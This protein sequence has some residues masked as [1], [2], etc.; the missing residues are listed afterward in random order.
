MFREGRNTVTIQ[1]KHQVF[2]DPIINLTNFNTNNDMI[3]TKGISNSAFIRVTIH[4]NLPH[5]EMNSNIPHTWPHIRI[6]DSF[7]FQPIVPSTVLMY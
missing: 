4:P 5:I 7:T 6:P 1:Q 2:D 3:T